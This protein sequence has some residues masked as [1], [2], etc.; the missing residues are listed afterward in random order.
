[1]TMFIRFFCLVVIW[2]SLDKDCSSA[3]YIANNLTQYERG[4]EIWQRA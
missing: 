3:H 2:S 4:L 1:M